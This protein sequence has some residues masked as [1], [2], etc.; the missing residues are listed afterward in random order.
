M[1]FSAGSSLSGLEARAAACMCV[2]LAR[3]FAFLRE[4]QISTQMSAFSVS[5]IFM[6]Y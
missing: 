5:P 1:S 4:E 2:W 6:G 3:F